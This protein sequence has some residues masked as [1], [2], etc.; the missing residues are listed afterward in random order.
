LWKDFRKWVKDPTLQEEFA[1]AMPR[2]GHSL[3][4]PKSIKKA[5]SC[6]QAA[7]G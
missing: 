3:H 5:T 1:D 4:Y 6:Q 2:P 7:T